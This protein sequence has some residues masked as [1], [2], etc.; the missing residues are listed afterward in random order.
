MAREDIYNNKRSYEKFKTE[1][2]KNFQVKTKAGIKGTRQYYCL[3]KQNIKFFAKLFKH[4]ET[5]DLSYI[6]R[7][8]LINHFKIVLSK[9]KDDLSSIDKKGDREA[10][11]EIIR[12]A[13]TRMSPISVT[14]FIADLKVIWKVLFPVIDEKGRIDE[15]ASPYVVRHLKRTI[16]KS[17]QE[18]RKDRL[19]IDEYL[20]VI[21]YLAKDIRMKLFVSLIYETFARP[22]ELLR[23]TIGD[24]KLFENYATIDVSSG[25]KEGTKMLVVIDGY[26]DLR[27]WLN[28]HPLKNNSSSLLFITLK[29]NN[30]NRPLTIANINKS[31]RNAC[32]DLNIKKRITCYSFKR[33]GISDS[34]IR[35]ESGKEIQ[36]KAG[37]TS[38]KQLKTY[39]IASEQEVIKQILIKK[40]V[41]KADAKNK[42][43][44]P[45]KK[46]CP[47][48][49]VYNDISNKSC[50]SC[51][52]LLWREDIEEEKRQTERR[53]EALERRLANADKSRELI[54]LYKKLEKKLKKQ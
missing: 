23:R 16:D 10:I 35:G 7:N 22:Q 28:K 45:T 5:V 30:R 34:L 25:G 17:T 12:F 24:V 18:R 50:D 37:W 6:R 51:G 13:R 8:R 48:C 15:N 49:N 9:A 43:I 33:N 54:E 4:F 29:G 46:Q 39:D 40:G 1:G 2:I 44:A 27:S 42:S 38:Q 32:A 36:T 20:K 52:H 19:S 26:Q 3:N 21:D 53:L 41:I 31:I 47:F 14:Y 11:D